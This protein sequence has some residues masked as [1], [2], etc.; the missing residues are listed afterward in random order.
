MTLLRLAAE[1]FVDRC[2]NQAV[3]TLQG[4]GSACA[5]SPPPN[6]SADGSF[7]A[8]ASSRSLFITVCTRIVRV[9]LGVLHDTKCLDGLRSPASM[10]PASTGRPGRSTAIAAQP[11]DGAPTSTGY[12]GAYSTLPLADERQLMDIVASG[13]QIRN[14]LPVCSRLAL[15]SIHPPESH[16]ATVLRQPSPAGGGGEPPGDPGRR[17]KDKQTSVGATSLFRGG[18]WS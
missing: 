13:A 1:Q 9:A 4:L 15:G 8:P 12:R 6:F 5:H 7:W 3:R 14:S 2:C 16:F 17:R 10:N 18:V 11:G